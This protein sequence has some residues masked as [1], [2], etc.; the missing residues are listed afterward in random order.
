M[1][2]VTDMQK[3]AITAAAMTAVVAMLA[4]APASAE[5]NPGPIKN[6]GQC[7]SNS[8][9]GNGEF[10]FWAACPQTASQTTVQSP[11]RQRAPASR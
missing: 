6:S 1:E 7:W 11:R 4:A 9:G 3:F 10:G 8:R 2:E 5:R